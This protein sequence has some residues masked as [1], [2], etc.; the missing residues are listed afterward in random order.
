MKAKVVLDFRTLFDIRTVVLQ[1]EYVLRARIL[2]EV[3][4][5]VD[6][7]VCHLFS[8]RN[9]WYQILLE[10]YYLASKVIIP[11]HKLGAVRG[12]QF[13]HSQPGTL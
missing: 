13:W 4:P 5:H 6:V 3:F 10:L 2:C 1:V 7:C 8:L 9:P 12:N 11:Y